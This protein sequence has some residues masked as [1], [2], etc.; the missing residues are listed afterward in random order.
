MKSS[1]NIREM[2]SGLSHGER[3]L[4]CS[5]MRMLKGAKKSQIRDVARAAA[6]WE[7]GI[8]FFIK[9]RLMNE[10]PCRRIGGG[11]LR[12][13]GKKA[14]RPDP[15]LEG[16]AIEITSS[17]TGGRSQGDVSQGLY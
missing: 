7:T 17:P 10:K 5:V 2:W 4:I 12:V 8:G 15:T 16:T 9:V 6:K 14:I 3:R 11:W 13:E 1:A